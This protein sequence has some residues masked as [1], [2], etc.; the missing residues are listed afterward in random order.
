MYSAEAREHAR[1]A[2]DPAETHWQGPR[3]AAA[4][5]LHH[6]G[7]RAG[8][9]RSR[10]STRGEAAQQQRLGVLAGKRAG[11]LGLVVS[12]TQSTSPA[13]KKSRVEA[14]LQQ[15]LGVLAGKPAGRQSTRGKGTRSQNSGDTLARAQDSRR[16]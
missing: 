14:A 6:G 15:R 1:R 16:S 13:M 2:V 7:C 3:T 5:S 11:Q 12:H 8:R 4:A 10:Q 9:L